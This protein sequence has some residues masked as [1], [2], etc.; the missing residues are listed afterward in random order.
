MSRVSDR[1]SGK[2]SPFRF[3]RTAQYAADAT[4]VARLLLEYPNG[5]THKV[6]LAEEL[7]L[8]VG[9]RFD[10]YGRSWRVVAPDR[11]RGRASAG[12]PTVICRPTSASALPRTDDGSGAAG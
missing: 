6:E 7:P 3:A 4:L 2:N 9:D 11:P 10:L 8:D 12:E 5:R 1:E